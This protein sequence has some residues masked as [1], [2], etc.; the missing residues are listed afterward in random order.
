MY[1]QEILDFLDYFDLYEYYPESFIHFH[2]CIFSENK[3]LF[4]IFLN[5]G[6]RYNTL[7][8]LIQTNKSGLSVY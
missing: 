6:N 1:N 5:W 2:K 7:D 8:D 4:N 3:P